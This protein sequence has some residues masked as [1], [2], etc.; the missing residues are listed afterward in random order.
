MRHVVGDQQRGS[1][2]GHV[3]LAVD[4][5]A[6]DAVGEQPEHEAD[7]V[8]RHDGDDVGGDQE[9]RKAEAE[10]DRGRR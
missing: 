2:E 1:A 10:H 6:E 7:Q 3:F 4:A 8:I 9:Q 5:D